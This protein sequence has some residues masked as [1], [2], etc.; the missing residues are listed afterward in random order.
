LSKNADVV[1]IGGG[2]IGLSVAWRLIKSGV[3]VAVLEQGQVGAQASGAAAGMLAPLSEADKPGPFVELGIASLRMYHD[4]V[5]DL[6][7]ATGL[8]TECVSPGLLRVAM[9]EEE[10]K[11]LQM[12]NRWQQ[13]TGLKVV[14]LTGE[15][16]R[17]VEP[18]LSVNIVAATLSPDEKQ[19]ES[20]RLVRAL[21]LACARKGVQIMEN[22]PV[23]GFQTSGDRVSH[24]KSLNDIWECAK[25]VIAGGAWSKAIGDWLKV[26]LPVSPIRGQILS[27]R[28]LPPPICFTIYSHAGYLVPR[29]DGRIVAGATAEEAGFDSRPTAG[30]IAHLLTMVPSLVPSLKEAVF[31]SVWAGLRPATPDH[32]PILGP[33]PGWQNVHAACGHF[34]NG[35]LLAPITG[36]V[37][38]MSVLDHQAHPLLEAFRADR[39]Q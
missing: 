36:E 15:E 11:S 27:L 19:Y 8:E 21:A 20:P 7:E 37:V 9:N 14:F 4:F 1:V 10:A 33:L 3:S 2:I 26:N 18:G 23:V 5:A 31:D 6:K 30:G 38:A 13:A 25:V 39:F 17:E 35:I 22:A 28:A 34:R 32:L 16:A 12:A 24:V 29:T